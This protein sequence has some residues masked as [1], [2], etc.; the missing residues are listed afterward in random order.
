MRLSP[1]CITLL[2]SE[3]DRLGISQCGLIE[4][5]SEQYKMSMPTYLEIN[6]TRRYQ[7]TLGLLYNKKAC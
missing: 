2:K 7:E 6:M 5:M 1:Y 4:L 3:A